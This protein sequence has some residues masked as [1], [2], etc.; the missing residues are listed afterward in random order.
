MSGVTTNQRIT[1]S[2]GSGM[3]TLEWLNMEVALSTT[4]NSTTARAGMP[5][6]S[7]AATLISMEIRIS[8]GWKRSPVVTSMSRSA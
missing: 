3:D 6:A 8:I 5:N 2:S 1:R 4:S 7:T